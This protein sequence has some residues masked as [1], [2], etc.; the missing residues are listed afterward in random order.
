MNLRL[1][2]VLIAVAVCVGCSAVAPSTQPQA[3]GQTP[4]TSAAPPS[5]SSSSASKSA[6]PPPHVFLVVEENRSFSTVYPSG[7][8]WLSALGD[9][10]GIATNYSS[11][12]PGSLTDYL[13]LSSGSG[14]AAFGCTGNDCPQT[15]TDNNI[16]REINKAGMTWKLYAESLPNAGFMGVSASDSTGTYVKRHNPAAWYSDVVNDPAQQ[17]NI[18]PFT[19]FAN[20]LKAGQLPN[21]SIIIPNLL[22]DAHDGT[23]LMADQW[24]TQNI[25]P[26]L[27]SS[28]FQPGGDGL[29][30]ITFDNGD[31]DAQGQVL[32]AVVGQAVIP[33]VQ[34]STAFRHEN[35]LRTI[36]EQL[37]LQN[38]PGASSTAAP[39]S[40]FFKTK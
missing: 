6:P 40:E 18:V 15:I 32:T 30:F 33:H 25:T 5:S 29:M 7:M 35:T 19:Q 11:D 21:Y 20:D 2:L 26:L 8:P 4:G 27:N 12:E 10:Y 14:E 28:Y 9:Q 31:G 23:P 13:W 39:M 1:L 3:V 36:M 22:H 34:V 17:Q 16:F 37:G 24:L 38:F